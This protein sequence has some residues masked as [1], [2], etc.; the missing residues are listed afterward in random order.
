[1][2]IETLIVGI[3]NVIAEGVR[4]AVREEF[5][6]AGFVRPSVTGLLSKREC[7]EALGVSIASLDRY[8]A[9]GRVPF[10]QVGGRRKFDLAVVRAALA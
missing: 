4:E 5:A 7:A 1:M 6:A 8:C 2:N 3:K 9:Q 10:V